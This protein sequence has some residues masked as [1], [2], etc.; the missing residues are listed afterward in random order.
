MGSVLR[1]CL[2]LPR[3]CF[4][5][6]Q[7]ALARGNGPIF[8]KPSASH[9][10]RR[11]YG[12]FEVRKGDRI[13][14]SFPSA[15]RSAPTQPALPLVY[16]PYPGAN[17]RTAVGTRGIRVGFSSHQAAHHRQRMQW[18]LAGNEGTVKLGV[19]GQGTWSPTLRCAQFIIHRFQPRSLAWALPPWSG[20]SSLGGRARKGVCVAVC[21]DVAG[22]GEPGFRPQRTL[23]GLRH[24]AADMSL[25]ILVATAQRQGIIERNYE[26]R[27]PGLD[28]GTRLGTAVGNRAIPTPRFASPITTC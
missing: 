4:A 17:T 19:R 22:S 28:P 11:R 3:C 14:C 13:T 12:C 2:T 15:R 8:P 21:D 16:E 18:A 1:A 5:L 24:L 26:R 20:T 23:Y 6:F 9:P 27:K 25:P 7:V 10:S